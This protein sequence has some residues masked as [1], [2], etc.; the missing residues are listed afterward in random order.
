MRKFT[1]R[2]TTKK[3]I[4]I[5]LWPSRKEQIF[6]HYEDNKPVVY[7]DTVVFYRPVSENESFV[8]I[9]SGAEID[10][11]SVEFA[12]EDGIKYFDKI[13]RWELK[14]ISFYD[15]TGNRFGIKGWQGK[16]SSNTLFVNIVSQK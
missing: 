4:V 2:N 3:D 15:F 1:L 7:Q 10:Y 8:T 13:G 14:I 5:C 11:G 6:T 16:I 12:E 9:R